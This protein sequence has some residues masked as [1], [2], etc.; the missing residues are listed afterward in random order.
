MLKAFFIQYDPLAC[1]SSSTL[2]VTSLS[3]DTVL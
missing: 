3:D 1:H 2:A